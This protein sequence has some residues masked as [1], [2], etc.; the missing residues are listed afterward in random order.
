MLSMHRYLHRD[1]SLKFSLPLFT[2]SPPISSNLEWEGWYLMGLGMYWSDHINVVNKLG[3]KVQV[4]IMRLRRTPR[5][6]LTKLLTTIVHAVTW[7]IGGIKKLY[8]DVTFPFPLFLARG[9][10]SLGWA[11]RKGKETHLAFVATCSNL[12]LNIII[13]MVVKKRSALCKSCAFDVDVWAGSAFS[14]TWQV[15]E[16]VNLW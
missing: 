3:A 9:N 1:T 7:G 12:D 14:L 4:V 6:Y 15:V 10:F 2:I 16:A 5:A 11:R 8:L 13:I